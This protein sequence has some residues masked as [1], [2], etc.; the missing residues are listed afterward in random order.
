MSKKA[1]SL[2]FLHF[3]Y[4][5]FISAQVNEFQRLSIDSLFLKC[6]HINKPGCA[7]AIIQDGEITY[8]K[9]YG[10]AD[11]ER[12]VV[13][14]PNTVFYAGSISKQFVASCA[15]LLSERGELD[16]SESVQKYLPDFPEY[17]LPIT[18]RHL[19][20]H[21]SGIKDYFDLMEIAGINYLNQIERDRI[22]A[23]IKSQDSLNFNPGDQY[24][25]S[26]SGYLML[27]MIIE[28]VAGMP[29]ARFVDQE[30]FKPLGMKHSIFLDNVNTIIP[31][32]AWGYHINIDDQVENMI[33]RFDLVGSG[34]LYT[35]VEDLFLWDQNFYQS[36]IGSNRF[37]E[38]LLTTGKLNNGQDTKYAFALQKDILMGKQVIGHSG[39]LG[40]Y[41]A[42][43]M[44]F[45]EART[46]IILLGNYSSFKPGERAHDIAKI[47][48]K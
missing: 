7:L 37:I 34:G 32:R 46:S 29:F 18:V 20:Y 36:K 11:L 6:D 15:L 41:R 39:S 1:L 40:G 13:I 48:L 22:Y 14:R 19:I 12:D 21:T 45:P 47:L 17:G 33:M 44:Q 23:L 9:G 2:I 35:T 25:Y 8:K 3:F 30:I 43:F 38:K 10:M 27:G 5:H 26:N 4:L 42:Q 16:L 24:S 28:K 31:N